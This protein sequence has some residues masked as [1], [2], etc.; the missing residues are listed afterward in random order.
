[1]ETARAEYGEEHVDLF[2]ELEEIKEE[3]V[4]S[5]ADGILRIPLLPQQASALRI[6]RD[7]MAQKFRAYETTITTAANQLLAQYHAANRE[8]RTSPA[9]TRFDRNW[10]LPHSFLVGPEVKSLLN[11]PAESPANMSEML[12]QLRAR[13]Q[14]V[15]DEYE[16][17]LAKFPHA[18]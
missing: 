16:A 17:L 6:E 5:L 1:V 15:L 4:T 9:P 12:G 10:E 14:A 8:R 11:D 2:D 13:S 18:I 3:A 7:A